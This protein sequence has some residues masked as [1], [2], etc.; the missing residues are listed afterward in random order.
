M[1]KVAIFLKTTFNDFMAWLEQ[2]TQY[3]YDELFPIDNGWLLLESARLSSS[4]RSN[5]DIEMRGHYAWQ[6]EDGSETRQ[7]QGTMIRFEVLQLNQGRVEVH[8]TCTQRVLLPY[9]NSLLG[10]IAK[11]WPE[12]YI[13]V[14]P[15]QSLSRPI[16]SRI[17]DNE[18]PPPEHEQVPLLRESTRPATAYGTQ[19]ATKVKLEKLHEIRKKNIRQGKVKIGWTVA[20][21]QV[22]ISPTTARKVDPELR[23][24]WYDE[25]YS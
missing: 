9:F 6:R 23:A 21:Q 1:K 11:R 2:R 12:S 5:R 10:D 20:C 14:A 15:M 16:E 24:H 19:E 18:L 7:D 3:V 8:A 13:E 17:P 22:T 25:S 4:L